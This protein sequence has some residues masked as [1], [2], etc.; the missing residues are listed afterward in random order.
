ML[1]LAGSLKSPAKSH[2]GLRR[3]H[4]DD[5]NGPFASPA[6]D[7]RNLQNQGGDGFVVN[8]RADYIVAGSSSQFSVAGRYD[9]EI[10]L[11]SEKSLFPF[12]M[13][14]LPALIPQ[15]MRSPKCSM[16]AANCTT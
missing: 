1:M 9:F 13:R 12:Q 16:P 10:R 5:L 11:M 2:G 15:A 6:E 3:R 14:S 8:G 4:G 7:F